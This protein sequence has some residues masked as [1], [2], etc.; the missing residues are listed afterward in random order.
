MCVSEEKIAVTVSDNSWR[1]T[2]TAVKDKLQ[3]QI[4]KSLSA[5][6]NSQKS[7]VQGQIPIGMIHRDYNEETVFCIGGQINVENTEKQ[8]T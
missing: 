7:T 2:T 6:E 1:G 8:I 5:L 4:H 3:G